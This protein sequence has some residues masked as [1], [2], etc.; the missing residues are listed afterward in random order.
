M[1]VDGLCWSQ[2]EQKNMNQPKN[3][4]AVADGSQNVL[5]NKSSYIQFLIIWKNMLQ[6][7]TCFCLID[8]IDY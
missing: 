6:E 7:R 4:A 3:K 5:Q 8:L 1:K 2:N